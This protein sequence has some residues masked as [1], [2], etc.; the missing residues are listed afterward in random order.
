M[1]G[2]IEAAI[3][4]FMEK[5]KQREARIKELSEKAEAGGVKGMAAKQVT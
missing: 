3:D 1:P 5:K 2:K 4:E